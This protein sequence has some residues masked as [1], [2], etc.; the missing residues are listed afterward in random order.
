MA[1]RHR[2]RHRLVNPR[3][4]HHRRR[5]RNSHRRRRHLRNPRRGG[6][7]MSIR[8]VVREAVAP[9]FVGGA[10]AVVIDVIYSYVS[11][12]VPA[13]LQTGFLAY[14]VKGA[15]A[16]GAGALSSRFVGRSRAQA[17]V[18]GALT[19][20]SYSAIRSAVSGMGIPGLSGLGF[21]DYTPYPMRGLGAYIRGPTGTPGIQ[22]LG[23]LGYV[24]PGSVIAPTLSPQM[25]AYMSPMNVA[26][27][28]G[29][30]G[31]GM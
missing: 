8:S 17:A 29:D 30:Y 21:R 1:R 19:V 2:R 9:A 27:H 12:Y 10:G 14:L 7:G 15:V 26:P 24:S 16:V 6:G 20:L 11:P 13:S 25:G 28:M 18:V 22:G 5:H 4:H 23:R 31:D 3:R